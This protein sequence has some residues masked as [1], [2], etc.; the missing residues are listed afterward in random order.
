MFYMLEKFF[1]LFI[2]KSD[3]SCH[4]VSTKFFHGAETLN[5]FDLTLEG[6]L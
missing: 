6:G 3:G 5:N 2:Q 4:A 1:L